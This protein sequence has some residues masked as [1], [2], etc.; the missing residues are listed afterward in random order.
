MGVEHCLYP[1]STLV[2]VALIRFT[3]VSSWSSVC[4]FQVRLRNEKSRCSILFH[5]TGQ[6][7]DHE[8]L[9]CERLGEMEA[10]SLATNGWEKECTTP[11]RGY[12]V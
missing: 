1:Q 7:D 4:P 11:P 5:L 6:F 2:V 10:G 3:M 9:S 12:R 8:K